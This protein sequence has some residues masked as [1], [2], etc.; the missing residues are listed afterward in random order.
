M[1]TEK[2]LEKALTCIRLVGEGK[3]Q[4]TKKESVKN[5]VKANQS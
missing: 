5:K 2:V 4:G 3:K 1:K